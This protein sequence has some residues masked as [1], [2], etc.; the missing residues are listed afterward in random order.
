MK[1][2]FGLTFDEAKEMILEY[3][4]R[5]DNYYIEERENLIDEYYI[6]EDG[7]TFEYQDLGKVS[8]EELDEALK[9]YTSQQP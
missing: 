5:E 2:D 8:Y 1:V 6:G 3:S 9:D 7:C 4:H